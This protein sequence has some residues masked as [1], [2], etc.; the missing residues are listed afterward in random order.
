MFLP[1]I[2]CAHHLPH[3]KCIDYER[4]QI[5]LAVRPHVAFVMHL[6]SIDFNGTFHQAKTNIMP[7]VRLFLLLIGYISIIV[8]FHFKFILHK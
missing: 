7:N 3:Y 6:G 5:L 2:R 1:E 8:K 4:N